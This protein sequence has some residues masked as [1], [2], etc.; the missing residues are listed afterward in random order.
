MVDKLRLLH[1]RQQ[2]ILLLLNDLLQIMGLYQEIVQYF[3]LEVSLL[4]VH[5]LILLLFLV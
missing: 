5:L 3:L 2:L 4:Q 1:N